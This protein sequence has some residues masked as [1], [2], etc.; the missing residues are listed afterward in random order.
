MT[1]SAAR[2][3]PRRPTRFRPAPRRVAMAVALTFVVVSAAACGTTSSS[4]SSG[5]GTGTTIGGDTAWLGAFAT[6]T[7]P[8]PVNT[9][10]DVSCPA[11]LRCW[12]VGSTVGG[13]GAP[14]GAVVLATANAGVTWSNQVIPPEAGYLSRIDCTTRRL[15]TAVGQEA[16]TSDGQAVALGTDDG[17]T[18]WVLEPV[19]ATVLDITALDCRPGGGCLAV[20][21]TAGGA[22]ALAADSAV[23]GW[24]VLGPLPAG[25]TGATS[26]SCTTA[27]DCW[28]TGSR[29]VDSDHV[30]G[31]VALTTDGGTTWTAV[32]TPKGLGYLN[33]VSCQAGPA[34][35]SGALPTTTVPAPTTTTTAPAAPGA[36]TTATTA[37]AATTTTATTPPAP[38]VGVAGADCVVVGTT[39][40]TLN[41]SRTGQGVLLDTGNGGATWSSPPVGAT[42]ASLAGVS[43]TT[44]GSCVVVGTTPS[45]SAAAGVIVLSGRTG[46]PWQHPAVVSSPQ[47][48]TAVACVSLSFC[49]VVGESISEHLA[50]G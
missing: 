39:S 26:L 27:D 36:S 15:C 18:S 11:T 1:T 41:G 13:A 43:C 48:L 5:T 32:A 46:G 6:E 14:N 33:G 28:A 16:Q 7:L 4:S 10:T 21:S 20:G 22:V 31:A 44:V 38:V 42:S 8:A 17:G 50:G 12:A 40:T 25:I 45:S 3:Q 49:V 30:A 47:S 9:L 19:P 37:P 23:A 34:T 29:A 35:G 2:H 24:T